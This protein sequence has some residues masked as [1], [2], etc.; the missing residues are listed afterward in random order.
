MHIQCKPPVKPRAM[1]RYLL[2]EAFPDETLYSVVSRF[3]WLNGLRDHEACEY[4]LGIQDRPLV[5]DALVDLAHFCGA[6]DNA[7]GEPGAVLNN[8]TLWPFFRNLAT[9]PSIETPISEQAHP[10]DACSASG[11]GLAALSNAQPH[12]WRLCPTCVARDIEM[13]GVTYWHRSHQLPGVAI[14]LLHDEPLRDIRLPHRA[15]Q[16]CFLDPETMQASLA[17]NA[18]RPDLAP[19]DA[20]MEIAR[21]AQSALNSRNAEITP[22]ILRGVIVDALATMGLATKAGVIHPKG[23]AA[24]FVA[25]HAKFSAL[26]RLALKALAQLAS[27]LSA[28]PMM[29][30]PTLSLLIAN[31]LHGSWE[32]FH[33]H[34]AWRATI[35]A[36]APC[37]RREALQQPPGQNR[38]DHRLT[39]LAFMASAPGASRTEFWHAHPKACRWLTQYDSDW[40]E[41]RLPRL[42]K[43]APRQLELF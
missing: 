17:E 4:L 13:F 19:A 12:V 27:G 42:K 21:F 20:A 18:A 39:C 26:E 8:L 5:S 24:R 33:A 29:F 43:H 14:C 9:H 6:T 30:P 15:R 22:A 34:C 2:P 10:Y 25:H 37:L 36:P 23:F 11:L 40:L 41:S 38:R 3:T 31:W 28:H 32:R 35:D 7:Y 16:K 1:T